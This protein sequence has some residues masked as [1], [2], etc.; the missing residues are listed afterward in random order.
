MRRRTA[1]EVKMSVCTPFRG[2]AG[3]RGSRCLQLCVHYM[4]TSSSVTIGIALWQ[5][6]C[7]TLHR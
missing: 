1:W 4:S 5:D 2:P 3:M 7:G 6:S